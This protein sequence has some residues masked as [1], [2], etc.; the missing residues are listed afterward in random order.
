MVAADQH[1]AAEAVRVVM[2]LVLTALALGLARADR[3]VI[4]ILAVLQ[5]VRLAEFRM[6][7][8]VAEE[9]ASR[10]PIVV[11][12]KIVPSRKGALVVIASKIIKYLMQET[13]KG[14]ILILVTAVIFGIAGF[15]TGKEFYLSERHGS[16]LFAGLCGD[17]FQAGYGAAKKR[18]TETG[19]YPAA[20]MGVKSVSG[21][22]IK[23]SG[24]KISLKIRPL[25]P[26][27]D[28]SLDIRI[29]ETDDNTKIYR[30]EQK[31]E[32]ERQ[33]EAA[34]FN[35]ALKNY[36][37]AATSTPPRPPSLFNK[38]EASLADIAT[39]AR[40]AVTADKDIKEVKKF[41]AVEIDIQP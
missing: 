33:K 37:A 19:F 6:Y 8:M 16:S 17:S 25:E 20:G 34:E 11:G 27:A 4:T 3:F 30:L 35:E 14:A 9:H 39:G 5:A 10:M 7:P 22:A 28:A 12:I 21:E 15:L 41:K 2:P 36:P 29:V 23:V 38:K 1:R 40:L 32:E 13:K 31:S 18:L 24:D 26:L